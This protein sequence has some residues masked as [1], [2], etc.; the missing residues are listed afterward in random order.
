MAEK[1]G[2]RD[3][4]DRG[5]RGAGYTCQK[6]EYTDSTGDKVKCEGTCQPGK[7][8]TLQSR[9]VGSTVSWTD[10]ASPSPRVSTKEYRCIC[11]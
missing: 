4:K 3:T 8:C 9:P 11:K 7:T 10:I 6:K 5:T 2:T 1:K